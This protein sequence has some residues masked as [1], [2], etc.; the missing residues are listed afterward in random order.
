MASFSV[1]CIEAMEYYMAI[2]ND[3]I[4]LYLLK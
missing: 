2:L 1:L 3:G 4:T